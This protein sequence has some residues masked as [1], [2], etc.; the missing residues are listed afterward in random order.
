M[1]D[2]HISMNLARILSGYYIFQ[3]KGEKLKLK[4]PDRNL[5]Y[6][7]E[8]VAS[9]ER[10]ENRF[11]DWL[12]VEDTESIL[13]NQ[14]L[15]SLRHREFLDKAESVSDSLK[16]QVFQNF[17][18]P[19]S[20]KK[21]KAK[22]RNHEKEVIRLS[23]IKDSLYYLTLEAFCSNLKN[24]YILSRSIY[25]ENGDLPFLHKDTEIIDV[26]YSQI[27]PEQYRAIGRSVQ[28]SYY[29][30]SKKAGSVFGNSIVDCTDEQRMLMAI[31]RMYDA[32]REH[33]E[34]PDDDIFEDDD[35]FD[36][37]GIIQRKKA[38]EERKK[39]RAE[40]NLPGNLSKANDVFVMAKTKEEIEDIYSLNDTSAKFII[41]E[42][43]GAINR[44]GEIAEQNLPDIQRDLIIE[45]AEAN[46]R[47]K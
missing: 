41:K 36:G 27:S 17:R 8:L 7:A 35:A 5:K 28:W 22:L 34:S 42:R 13:M 23:R 39:S 20:L 15:W 3:Y 21:I 31:S 19:S 32:A 12:T 16:T 4:Y 43:Q 2:R 1:E 30:S 29:W 46:K 38:E 11:A 40:K 9:Q 10:S 24:A 14:G 33:P 26:P 25:D 18:N 37:W 47:R 44:F 45:S 6:E